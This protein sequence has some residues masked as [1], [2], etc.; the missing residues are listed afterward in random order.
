M[1]D[2]LFYTSRGQ[3]KAKM[4]LLTTIHFENIHKFNLTLL[5]INENSI[6]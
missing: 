3:D 1:S 2:E 6:I 5:K 4:K